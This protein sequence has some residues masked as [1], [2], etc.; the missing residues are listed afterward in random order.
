MPAIT[1]DIRFAL[2]QLRRSPVFSLVVMGTIALAVG[3]AAAMSGILRASLLHPL[4]Y[5]HPE[6][7]VQVGDQNLRG[8]KTNGLMTVLRTDDLAQLTAEGRPLFSSLGF[9]YSH[10]RRPDPAQSSCCCGFRNLLPD[11]RYTRTPR[12]Y[13]CTGR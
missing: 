9:F 2:R 6:Q 13:A 3:A 7:L 11:R 12:T 4:P 8:F 10:A 5:P 1:Q